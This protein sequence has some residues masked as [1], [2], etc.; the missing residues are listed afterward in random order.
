[1]PSWIKTT[2]C[3]E[4]PNSVVMLLFNVVRCCCYGPV[5]TSFLNWKMSGMFI[6][7]KLSKE[8]LKTQ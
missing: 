1:M 5:I 3:T 2:L 6:H 8:F 4:I 7:L